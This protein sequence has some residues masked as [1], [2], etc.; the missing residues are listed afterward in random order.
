MQMR[1]FGST[2]AKV[3]PLGFGSMRLPTREGTQADANTPFSDID[4][5]GS[6]AMIRHAIDSG[7]NYVDTA[8]NYLGGNSEKIVGIALQDGYR[9]KTF[10]AT[11][12]PAWLYKSEEDFDRYL[13]EQMDRLQTDH[14]D[15]Y[16]IHSLNGGSWKRTLRNKALDAL[17][18][19]QEDGRIT[20]AGFSFHDDYELFEEI[21]N[22]YDWDFCQIQLNYCDTEH[23]AG[24]KGMK[25][26]AEKG[27]GVVVMEPLRG[28]FLV[29]VPPAVQQ[30]FDSASVKHSNVEWAF[31]FLW[32][33][34]EISCV[35]TGPTNPEVL[36]EDIALAKQSYPHM[37]SDEEKQVLEK[38]AQAY[39]ESAPIPCTG[40]NY[41]VEYC[42]QKLT[43]PYNLLAYNLRFIYDD[44][45]MAR[46]YYHNEVPKFGKQA[47]LC[48][49]CGTCEEICPQHIKI[50][51][52]M[53]KVCELLD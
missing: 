8:Y 51:E 31:D 19:A 52:W 48:T 30:V 28:G 49:G 41:C 14:I 4:V 10:L 22:A 32:D 38:A 6:V 25:K 5:E 12:S 35:L 34:P 16:L 21:L 46:D 18:R 26:A 50:S 20:Y 13:A 42:P 39:H 17:K 11:K 40:C 45:E 15:M 3:S 7:I 27:M 53:P 29:D 37:M 44:L 23:Q 47:D 2:G 9:E 43:I 36:K 24:I 33:M 1:E